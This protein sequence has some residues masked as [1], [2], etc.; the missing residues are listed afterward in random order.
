MEKSSK[1]RKLIILI[2]VMLLVAVIALSV[3]LGIIESK[4]RDAN[5]NL[6]N[7]Y[8]KSYTETITS[9][10]NISTKLS[11]VT[12]LSG[13]QLRQQLLNDIWRECGIAST[14]LSQ[15]A[16]S[17]DN[18]NEAIKVLNQIGDYC[19]YLGRKITTTQLSETEIGHLD[20]FS[21]TITH[22]NT[23][24][25]SVQE[26]LVQGDKI[27][28]SILSNLSAVTETIGKIDYTSVDYPE[29]IYDGPFSEGL[30]NPE[31]KFLN[32]KEEIS[33]TRGTE[34]IAQ[35]FAGCTDISSGG[36]TAEP[37]P[38]YIYSFKYN[39]KDGTAYL[40]KL[41]GYVVQFDSYCE[42]TDPLLSDEECLQKAEAYIQQLGY[43]NMKPV[44]ISNNNS[45]V[46]INFA[47][48]ENDVVYYPDLIKIKVCNDT[49]D[50]IGVE[51]VNF[52]YNHIPRTLTLPANAD[53]INIP[54]SLTVKSQIFCLIPT[55]WKSEILCLEVVAEKDE[56]VF[57]IYYNA[58]T[59][60]EERVLL[61][62]DEDG[63]LLI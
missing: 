55:D 24:L 18:L 6:N 19:Q 40:S 8:E 33:E 53:H 5:T 43:S 58:E 10:D 42:V 34:L 47:Y 11:K 62:I 26:N 49:G 56:Q 31:T 28:S 45:T 22:L 9:L 36:E 27:D 23:S 3:A 12:V 52:I 25:S 63:Q 60:E 37:I 57:Y 50:M 2:G 48:T 38:S 39:G 46:Y 21:S 51:A 44:W 29:L 35:Y 54:S 17:S 15:M 20:S 7:L 30:D 1:A 4:R 61:V 32:D 13:V 14:N 59:G 41:G 16:E